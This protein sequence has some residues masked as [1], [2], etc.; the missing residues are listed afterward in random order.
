MSNILKRR[1]AINTDNGV[2]ET[3]KG[4]NEINWPLTSSI[5]I[6][7]GSFAWSSLQ[8]RSDASTPRAKMTV[9]KIA[10][11]S[12]F[13]LEDAHDARSRRNSPTPSSDPNVPGASGSKPAPAPVAKPYAI[14]ASTQF[15]DLVIW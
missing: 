13:S 15:G 5:T 4:L 9:L 11:K 2:G 1:N 12:A 6:F 3:S 7:R 10:N 8:V 14:Q